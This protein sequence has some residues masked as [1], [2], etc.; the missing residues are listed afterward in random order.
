MGLFDK[1][2]GKTSNWLL[3]VAIKKGLK[4]LVQIGVVWL[5]AVQIEDVGVNVEINQEIA[6]VALWSAAEVGRSW[7]K[8]KLGF[9]WL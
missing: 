5:A 8:R 2:K 6:F 7:L 3:N 4:R 9:D 1:L